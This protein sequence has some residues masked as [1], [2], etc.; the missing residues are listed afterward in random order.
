MKITD[1]ESRMTTDDITTLK[2]MF[3]DREGAV[4]VIRKI[5]YPE[6]ASGNPIN[7]NNDLFTQLQIS[8]MSPEQA[9]IAVTARQ[10]L[11]RHVEGCFAVIKALVGEKGESAEQTLARLQKNSAK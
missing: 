8:E 1:T 11:V 2:A 9:L 10:Q 6:L 3:E 7:L 5:F 4:E